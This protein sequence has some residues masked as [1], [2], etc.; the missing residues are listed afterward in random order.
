MET[1]SLT[2][3]LLPGDYAFC[4]LDPAAPIPTW[5][6]DGP[7][8]SVTRTADE[9]SIFCREAGAP[10]DVKASRGWH[11]LKVEGLLD[12]CAVGVIASFA[13]PLAEAGL[14]ISVVSTYDT[15]YLFVQKPTLEHAL[16]VLRSL[17]HTIRP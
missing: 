14:S 5:A 3:T 2:F 11:C 15:D 10:A 9:L 4:R 8:F 7:F 1:R 13:G 6:T 12:F 16:A 17:G